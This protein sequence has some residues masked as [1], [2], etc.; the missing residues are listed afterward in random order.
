[1]RFIVIIGKRMVVR[2][3]SMGLAPVVTVPGPTPVFVPGKWLISM[4]H[5][6]IH[7][8]SSFC[9][10]P[11]LDWEGRG[12]ERLGKSAGPRLPPPVDVISWEG[13]GARDR[14]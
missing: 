10:C 1:V 12:P 7:Y 4:S 11:Y 3:L 5:V 9:P 13:E 14:E 6:I 2:Y 8:P